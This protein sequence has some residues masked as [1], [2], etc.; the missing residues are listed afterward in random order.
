MNKSDQP[1]LLIKKF[2]AFSYGNIIA[3]G[4]GFLITIVSTRLFDPANFGKISL[5]RMVINLSLIS[6]T[7]GTDQS[8]SRFFY[9]E[10]EN[11]RRA[12]LFKSLRVPLLMSITIFLLIIANFEKLSVYLY[13]RIDVYSIFMLITGMFF[14]VLFRYGKVVIRMFEKGKTFSNLSILDKILNLVL[15]ILLYNLFKDYR[16]VITAYSIS[17]AVMSLIAVFIEKDFW[18]RTENTLSTKFSQKEIMGYAVP[19]SVNAL[20]MRLFNSFDRIALSTLSTMTEIGLYSVSYRMISLLDIFKKSFSNF[21]VPVSLKKYS[22][23]ADDFVFFENMFNYVTFFMALLS[24]G[25]IFIKDILIFLL[26]SNYIEVVLVFPFMVFIPFVQVTSQVTV[27]GINFKKKSRWHIYIGLIAMFVNIVGNIIL[28]PSLGAQGAA[29]ATAIS[30]LVLFYLRTTVA[31]KFYRAKYNLCKFNIMVLI[32]II[33][34]AISVYVN[35]ISVTL[36]V[37]VSFFLVVI[38]VYRENSKAI[39]DFMLNGLKAKKI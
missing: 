39:V 20:I 5:F 30:Y 32:L 23:N 31:S 10:E 14:S 9:E 6:I 21:W 29:I 17:M 37:G 18:N 2:I 19:N 26:G 34:S 22:E 35:K 24:I 1:Q 7:L 13:E 36:Y 4:I 11:R 15:M 28:V 3:M 27:S 38:M 16:A 25:L 8:F 12:L 33:Y